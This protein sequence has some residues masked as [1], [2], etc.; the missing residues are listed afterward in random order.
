MHTTFNI[1]EILQMAEQIERNGAIFYRRAA[2]VA[3]DEGVRS[4]LLMLASMED[5]HESLFATMQGTLDNGAGGDWDLDGQAAGY[6]NAVAAGHVFD[7][8]TDPAES[9]A[10]HPTAREILLQAIGREKDAIAFFIGLKSSMPASW[11]LDRLDEIIT[12]ELSHIALLSDEI[13]KLEE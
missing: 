1:D 6:L 2:E 5:D 8:N 12:E 13:K 10:A 4:T 9:L 3:T 7:L 11:G